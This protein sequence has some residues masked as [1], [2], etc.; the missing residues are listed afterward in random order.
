MGGIV[1]NELKQ[2]LKLIAEPTFEEFRRNPFSLRHAFLAC[3]ATYHA[4]DRAAYPRSPRGLKQKWGH[5]SLEFRLVDYVAHDFK[6]LAS[7][8]EKVPAG[9]IP[10]SFAIYGRAGFNTHSFNDVGQVENL[11]N[12]VFV[13]RDAI[14]FLHRKA[15]EKNA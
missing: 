9:R 7:R 3:V 1:M 14:E 6:H 12:L 13:V 10:L 2:Y 15:A 5:E 4:V 8:R 11:R